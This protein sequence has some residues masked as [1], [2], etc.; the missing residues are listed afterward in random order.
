MNH[1]A[2][3]NHATGAN[4]AADAN[5]AAYANHA[6]DVPLEDPEAR[7]KTRKSVGEGVRTII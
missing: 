7:D 4:N 5:Q 6:P 3:A 1:A 2:D